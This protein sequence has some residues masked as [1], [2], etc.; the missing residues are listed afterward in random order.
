M[1]CLNKQRRSLGWNFIIALQCKGP[2][3]ALLLFAT[4]GLHPA[5]AKRLHLDTCGPTVPPRGERRPHQTTPTKENA[6]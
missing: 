2:C 4:L 3:F 1:E 5:L 6:K